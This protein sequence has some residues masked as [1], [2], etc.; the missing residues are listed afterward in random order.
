M[1]DVSINA[2]SVLES[3]Q[4]LET[5]LKTKAVRAGLVS[6]AKPIKAAAKNLAPKDKGDLAKAIG[7]KTLSKRDAAR[8][9]LYQGSSN[10]V[11]ENNPGLAIII[12]PNRKVG[13][14]SQAYIG[15]LAEH[16]TK[17]R[18]RHYRKARLKHLPG[19]MHGGTE[20][21]HFMA[22]ALSRNQGDIPGRFYSGLANHLD[23]IK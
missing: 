8:I 13:G 14:K 3:L 17:K 19:Y 2:N 11:S 16:G 15:T 20:G 21:T 18:F 12:G 1:I 10:Q 4:A 23:R 6:V 7:H 5:S 9:D 22:R